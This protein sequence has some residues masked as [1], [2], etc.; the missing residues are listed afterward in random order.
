MLFGDEPVLVIAINNWLVNNIFMARVKS[1][2]DDHLLH[3]AREVFLE[4][5]F[6]VKTTDIAARAGV[7]SGSIFR[8]FV[9]KET[10]FLAAM[11]IPSSGMEFDAY[12]GLEDLKLALQDISRLILADA[13]RQLPGVVL[14]WAQRLDDNKLN[15]SKLYVKQEMALTSFLNQQLE[16]GRLRPSLDTIT[17]TR[18][19]T[20]TMHYLAW[21]E[22]LGLSYEADFIQIFV[23]TLWK[24]LVANPE[25]S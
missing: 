19:I 15:V 5:G 14:L 23:D 2:D 12:L 9:D 4:Q 17:T 22:M 13:R 10:L 21:L 16:Q 11:Q 1:I 18:L 7:S 20:G 3:V 6:A 24:G 8:R 25:D